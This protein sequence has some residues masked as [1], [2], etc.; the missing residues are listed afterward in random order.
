MLFK[1]GTKSR[2]SSHILSH[3]LYYYDLALVQ[4]T[5]AVPTIIYYYYRFPYSFPLLLLSGI[6]AV[7]LLQSM[8]Q[9]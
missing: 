8:R 3:H 2:Q 9:Y 1:K 4:C 7:Y 6:S 5:V